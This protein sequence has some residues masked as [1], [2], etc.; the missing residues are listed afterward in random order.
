MFHKMTPAGAAKFQARFA[1]EQRA[2][3]ISL[4]HRITDRIAGAPWDLDYWQDA[5]AKMRADYPGIETWE[6]DAEDIT[7]LK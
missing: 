3:R 6:L 5:A 2:H 7:A 1:K 4:Y